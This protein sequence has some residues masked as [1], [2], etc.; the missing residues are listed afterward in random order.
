MKKVSLDGLGQQVD[1]IVPP[2]AN[3]RIV[4]TRQ[5]K[6]VAIVTA[7]QELDDEDLTY[8]ESSEF[9]KTIAARRGEKRAPLSDVKARL[10]AREQ[11]E[12]RKTKD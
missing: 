10:Q 8:L 6:A 9:W 7:V 4:L 2:D 11:Q 5:G 12:V 3:E 1:Q